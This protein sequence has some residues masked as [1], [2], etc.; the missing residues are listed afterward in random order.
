MRIVSDT[1]LPDLADV[2]ARVRAA[3]HRRD[4]SGLRLL[5]HGEVSIVL[6]WPTDEPVHA[7]KRVPP[8]RTAALAQQY[9]DACEQNFAVLRAAEV[10]LWPTSLHTVVRD[11]GRVVVY[12]RQPVADPVQIGSNVLRAAEPADSHP[13]LDVIVASVVR[14]VTPTVGF[15]VQVANWL[16]DGTTAQQLDF[17]SPFL[18]T[19][20]RDDLLFD[21]S[22][23][24]QEYPAV[25]RPLLRRE[26]T[27]LIRRLTTAEGAIGDMI[28]NL[29]KEGLHQWV[30]PAIRAARNVAGVSVDKA[31]AIKMYE[32][33]KKLMPVAL[34]LKKVQR[35]WLVRTGRTYDSLL[36]DRT[37]YE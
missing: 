18:M 22:G 20:A 4:S 10:Q 1:D 28:S 37:T 25:L 5:G 21:T 12:H 23:F 35:A 15:D 36:P 7:L 24:L 9:I 2:E 34:K 29:H 8:F 31:T 16:W 6:G 32:D 27:T 33:D 30:D 3:I 26:L 14:V 13:L 17:T 19:P 11:D